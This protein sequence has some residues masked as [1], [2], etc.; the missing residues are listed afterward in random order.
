MG[1]EF[2]NRGVT[3]IDE[4]NSNQDKDI[5]VL[6]YT[7]EN[8]QKKDIR[9]FVEVIY[10]NFEEIAKVKKLNHNRTQIKKYITSDTA[11]I[12]IA[13]YNNEI[14]SYG[15]ADL[16]LYNNRKL[17][18][19]YYLFTSPAY[20]NKGVATY[21]INQIQEYASEYKCSALSLTFDTYNKQ[22]S[23]YYETNG[24]TFDPDLRSKQRYDMIV[25][26]I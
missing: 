12:I 17:M 24:F 14:I 21:L 13:T 19:I 22:L 7:G 10:R 3:I 16:V 2:V 9:K 18:H 11:L 15:I 6:W 5:R 26:Y 8:L 1:G 20:R 4:R 25:K 23:K